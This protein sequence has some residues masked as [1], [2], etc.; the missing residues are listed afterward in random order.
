MPS[1]SPARSADPSVIPPPVAPILT[2]EELKAELERLRVLEQTRSDVLG[3]IAPANM[4]GSSGTP[5]EG[6]T[7]ISQA[8]DQPSLHPEMPGD[9]SGAGTPITIDEPQ[10]DPTSG[11]PIRDAPS[12]GGSQVETSALPADAENV[13]VPSQLPQDSPI[14]NPPSPPSPVTNVASVD[15]P[16]DHAS[17]QVNQV[18]F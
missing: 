4:P 12:T 1:S 3:G 11:S 8:D 14:I 16:I 17:T 5:P 18:I 9:T 10:V 2:Y 15:P 6:N 7:D 13:N